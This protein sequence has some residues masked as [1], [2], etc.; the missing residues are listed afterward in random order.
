MPR[1]AVVRLSLHLPPVEIPA[2]GCAPVPPRHA[3]HAGDAPLR[4]LKRLQQLRGG[5]HEPHE[6]H[7]ADLVVGAADPETVPGAL[8]LQ[9]AFPPATVAWLLQGAQ[10]W[11]L[12]LLE[13]RINH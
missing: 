1:E 6:A 7:V 2:D 11:T 3:L 8:V 4:G 9:D 13:K 12:E 10:Y 5:R